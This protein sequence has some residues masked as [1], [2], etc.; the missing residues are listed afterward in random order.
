MNHVHI[1]GSGAY[2]KVGGGGTLII[3]YNTESIYY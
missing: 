3:I 1:I 2:L